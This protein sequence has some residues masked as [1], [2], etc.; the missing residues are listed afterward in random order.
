MKASAIFFFGTSIVIACLCFAQTPPFKPGYRI[1]EPPIGVLGYRIRS[2][3]TVEGVSQEGDKGAG[4]TLLVDKIGNFKLD[5]PVGIGVENVTLPSSERCVLKGYETGTW[6]GIPDEVLRATGSPPP[7]AG[8]QFRFYF[9]A[10]SVES[11]KTLKI[12]P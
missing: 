9:R 4:H 2:Y 7:Q 3:L 8:W 6:V 10:T 11:P 5:P 12:E 1:V